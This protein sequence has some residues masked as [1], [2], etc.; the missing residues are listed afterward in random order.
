MIVSPRNEFN[1]FGVL[2]E[3]SP[4][5]RRNR[6][7]EYRSNVDRDVMRKFIDANAFLFSEDSSIVNLKQLR[8]A[9][10]DSSLLRDLNV[11][12]SKPKN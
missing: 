8:A 12:L 10:K 7:Y 4:T 6:I 9:R 11:K 1:L 2:I 5:N 3:M